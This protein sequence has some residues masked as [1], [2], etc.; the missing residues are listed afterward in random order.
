MLDFRSGEEKIFELAGPNFAKLAKFKTAKK[1]MKYGSRPT[2]PTLS[3][4]I[5]QIS[6]G[7][8]FPEHGR[9]DI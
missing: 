1:P 4:L 7:T 5:D 9:R 3:H 6:W 2:L 8:R